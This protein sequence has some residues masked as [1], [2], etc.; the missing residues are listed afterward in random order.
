MNDRIA[1]ALRRLGPESLDAAEV[2]GDLHRGRGWSSY[3]SLT[4]PDFDVCSSTTERLYDVMICEQVLEHV[5]D[6]E[7]AAKTLFESTVPGGH[8]VVSTPFLIRIH[9]EP[10]DLWRFTALGLR[11]LLERAGFDVVSADSWGNRACVTANLRHWV[12]HRPWRSLR[13][14]DRFPVVTWALARRPPAQAMEGG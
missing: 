1:E 7:R 9:D 5:R 14:D 11:V 2:S 13:N 10:E 12:V 3:V 4:F 6:P 8:V